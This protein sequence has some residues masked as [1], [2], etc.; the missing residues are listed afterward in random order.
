MAKIRLS[1]ALFSS[2]ALL[3]ISISFL[4][5]SI[6][7]CVLASFSSASSLLFLSSSISP[8]TAAVA[9]AASCSRSSLSFYD[10]DLEDGTS[11]MPTLFR[12]RFELFW[13]STW[14]TTCTLDTAISPSAKG[15]VLKASIFD[16][17]NNDP[18]LVDTYCI[19]LRRKYHTRCILKNKNLCCIDRNWRQKTTITNLSHVISYRKQKISLIHHIR[20]NIS[21]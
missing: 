9:S 16:W 19:N 10:D 3:L 11:L 2:I 7:F 8:C 18:S 17:N 1:S 5:S 15:S 12:K 14:D 13:E 21:H 6:S 4:Y 20:S